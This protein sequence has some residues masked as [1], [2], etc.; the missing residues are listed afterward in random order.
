MNIWLPTPTKKDV[1]I[2]TIL[3]LAGIGTICYWAFKLGVFLYEHIH[4]S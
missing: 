2:L 4:W 3:L 1:A